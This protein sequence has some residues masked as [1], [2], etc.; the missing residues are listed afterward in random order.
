MWYVWQTVREEFWMKFEETGSFH[1]L[2]LQLGMNEFILAED[3]WV[4]ACTYSS[5]QPSVDP[6][7]KQ[8]QLFT[9]SICSSVHH[10]FSPSLCVSHY[11]GK[12]YLAYYKLIVLWHTQPSVWQFNSE[13]ETP[14]NCSIGGLCPFSACW[15]T[16]LYLH[17]RSPQGSLRSCALMNVIYSWLT[18][19][20]SFLVSAVLQPL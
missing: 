4:C 1:C 12:P 5:V 17:G 20:S 18:S 19:Q 8:W 11:T 9:A 14:V 7:S 15:L 10:L 16:R 6:Q 3:R 2:S 13:N